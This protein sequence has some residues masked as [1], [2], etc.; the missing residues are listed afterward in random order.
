MFFLIHLFELNG[1]IM[2][3]SH[4]YLTPVNELGSHCDNFSVVSTKSFDEIDVRGS[5]ADICW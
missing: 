1:L 5:I 2:V 4:S 3:E